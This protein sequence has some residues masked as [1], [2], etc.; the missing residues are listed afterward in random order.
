MATRAGVIERPGLALF[1]LVG[2]GRV[3][4]LQGLVTCDVEQPGD[5]A[6]VFG[7]LLTVKGMIVSPLW[8]TRLADALVIAVPADAA[9]AVAGAFERSLPPRLCRWEDATSAS[10]PVGLYGPAAQ[11]LLA[12]VTEGEPPAADRA[13]PLRHGEA[14]VVAARVSARGL[15]GF[16]CIVPSATA[17]AFLAALAARGAVRLS[18]A[19]LE[20]RRILAGF[21]RLGAEI[22]EKTLPQEVR[23]DELGGV[24][25]TKG[26]YLGQ[27]TVA[28]IHFRGHAN[29][30]LA[31]L[32][33]E[34][35]P[36]SLPC[37]ILHDGQPAGRLTSACWWD[38]G[39]SWAGLAVV[40]RGTA[41]G[42][43]VTLPDGGAATVRELP[44]EPAPHGAD[45][46]RVFVTGGTGLV[47]RHVIAA[48]R[49]PR[50]RGA[51]ARPQRRGGRGADA[52]RN[53]G[54]ARRP[55][56]TPRASTRSSRARTRWCTRRPSCSRAAAGPPGTRR[57]CSA[58]NGWRAA[59]R[60]TAPAWSTYRRW[61]CTAASRRSTRAPWA[62]TRRSTSSALR[63][64][65]I[66]MPDPSGKRRSPCGASP[67]KRRCAPW[68]CARASSMERA[69]GT[70][71]PGSRGCCAWA[72]RRWSV[73][74][75]TA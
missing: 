62:W 52:A 53:G 8:I 10:V 13:G 38:A 60:V 18:A 54:G 4:C 45:A 6:H 3:A 27:E 23:L 72:S 34:R 58:P 70:S 50:R 69:I 15:D 30:Y 44:W 68:P 74:G 56:P 11:S 73:T 2:S 24:S 22:D 55:R 26:C 41:P 47:G 59:P 64:R 21:P 32:A 46:V 51:R 29:R 25:Y 65:A 49:A 17:A 71:R 16:D 67:G 57:T 40:R 39:R 63:R 33:L 43:S 9:A 48:L 20:E 7:A 28:R 12:A 66:S 61:R 35:E 5:G 31:G 42:S 37:E 75:R 19:L 1:R 36:A 14:T